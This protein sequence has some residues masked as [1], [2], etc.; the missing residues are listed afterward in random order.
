MAGILVRPGRPRVRENGPLKWV[1]ES[2]GNLFP[3]GRLFF[4]LAFESQA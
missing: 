1:N 4:A 3:R 2:R